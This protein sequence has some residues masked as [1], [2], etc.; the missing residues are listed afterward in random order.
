MRA[1]VKQLFRTI[2]ERNNCFTKTQY[3]HEVLI[4]AKCPQD[5]FTSEDRLP[6]VENVSPLF[7][8]EIIWANYDQTIST[9]LL[10][11]KVI[12]ATSGISTIAQRAQ[13]CKDIHQLFK[14]LK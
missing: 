4:F 1:L 6:S 14:S 9:T 10:S 8:C 5:I 2:Q 13:T 3:P 11:I 12:G 7:S